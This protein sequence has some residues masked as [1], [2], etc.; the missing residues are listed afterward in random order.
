MHLPGFL[1][2][3]SSKFILIVTGII[4]ALGIVFFIWQKNK[5]KIVN[6]AIADKVAKATDNLYIVKYDSLHFDEI[7]GAVYLKNIHI[8]PDTFRIK[9]TNTED[10]PYILLDIKIASINV[11][12]VKTDK[13]LLG[14]QMVG[15]SVVITG[16]QVTVYFLK[17]LKKETKIDVEAKTVYDEILGNLKLIKAGHVFINNATVKGIGFLSKEKE[18]DFIN[19][20]VQ[21]KDVLIDSAHNLD[22]TRTLFCKMAD[23][24]VASF[25]TYN[26]N[27]P[28]LR[29]NNLNFRGAENYFSF[30]DIMVNRF[31][32]DTSDGSKLLTAENLRLNGLDANE[33]VKNKNIIIKNISCSH[34][35]LYEPPLSGLKADPNKKAK[36]EDSTGFRHVYSID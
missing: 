33:F 27:R 21:L 24:N 17:P 20:N 25:I 32:N 14:Q 23:V 10:L 8:A 18:F 28:E 30:G 34:I 19:G 31:D 1:K 2:S 6:K 7:S 12:G 36:K 15:D 29:V 16:P 5:Y 35:T 4:I 3:L 22:T 11:T 26:I 13:A 9:N